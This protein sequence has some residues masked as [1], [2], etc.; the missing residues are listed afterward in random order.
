VAENEIRPSEA[1]DPEIE[2]AIKHVH[3]AERDVATALVAEARA[4]HELEV[5]VEELEDAERDR[6]FWVVVNGRRKEVHKRRLTFAQVVTLAFPDKPPSDNI[7]YTVAYRNG[8]NDR[9]PE[10][11]IV[12]GESVKIKD[13]T[14]FDVTATDK[15]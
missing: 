2:K 9:H 11:T 12:A 8:G 7:I 15:S 5:A 13:G 4:E 10:G 6:D 14:I 1:F 3:D